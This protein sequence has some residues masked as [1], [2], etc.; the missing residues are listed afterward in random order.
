MTTETAQTTAPSPAA[1]PRAGA[2]EWAGL[3]VLALAL[4]LLAVDA[5]VLD[6]AVPAISADLAPTTPQLLWIIDVYSFVLAGLLVVMGN[7][8]DRIG[9][10]RLLLLGAAAFGVASACAAW[11]VTPEMLIAARVLQG[12]AGATLMPA[13]LALI[14]SMFLAPRQ[15]TVA[16]AGWCA[17]GGGGAAGGPRR[18]G[19]RREHKR[20]GLVFQ[21]YFAV[22]LVLIGH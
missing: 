17:I 15:R 10:R 20:G 1:A 21:G 16:K 6:L 14:R 19:G 2:R 12:V 8:G 3:S 13:T 11:S 7:L 9:R 18:G 22:I 5:T 4:L